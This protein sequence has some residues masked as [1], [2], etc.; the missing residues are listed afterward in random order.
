VTATAARTALVAG[1]TGLVGGELLRQLATN[2]AYARVTAL[3]RRA[4]DLPQG[5]VPVIADF[6]RLDQA[7]EHLGAN[8]VFCALGT[9][10][11]K[12]GSQAAFRRVDHHYV[13][14]LAR[15]ARERGARHFLLVS[16]IGADARSRVFY[17]RVKGEVEADVQTLGYPSL[18]IVRPSFLLG[19]RAEFRLVEALMTPVV[20]LLPRRFRGVQAWAVAATLIRAATEDRSG[21]RVIESREIAD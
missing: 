2:S 3:V 5:V 6:E 18:T 10:I 7:A 15:L 8:H 1:A 11:R 20:P 9:T 21:V 12:A 16:S 4:A 17:P 19:P 13:V 14:S